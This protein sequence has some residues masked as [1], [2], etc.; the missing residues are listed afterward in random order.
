MMATGKRQ[1]HNSAG[2]PTISVSAERTVQS[3]AGERKA[4]LIHRA[5]L[6]GAVGLPLILVAA[7]L[8][9]FQPFARPS[10][11]DAVPAVQANPTSA[12]IT[13]PIGAPAV[14]ANPTSAPIAQPTAAP[15]LQ[16]DPTS[17]PA[18]QPTAAPALQATSAPIAVGVPQP[19]SAPGSATPA[20]DA[21]AGLPVYAG[22]VCVKHDPEND[23][24]VIKSE[25]TYTSAA[26]ADDVRRFFESAF[27]ANGWVLAESSHD[28]EDVAWKYTVTQGQRR[29]KV[30]VETKAGPSGAFTKLTIAEK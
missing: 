8:L 23:D 20:C 26:S 22:V 21:I 10:A 2:K 29:L 1:R 30:E 15:A 28:A 14:Q 6:I 7:I 9:L 24:G 25:N 16:A 12:P 18:A 4:L 5:I 11:V 13:Q 19:A 3:L 17:A 27:A